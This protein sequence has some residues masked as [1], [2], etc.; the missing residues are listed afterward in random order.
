MITDGAGNR[1]NKEKMS[2][3]VIDKRVGECY[4]VI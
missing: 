1:E 3:W 2:T 4:L